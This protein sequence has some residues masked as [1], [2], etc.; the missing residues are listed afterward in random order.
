MS[1]MNIDAPEFIYGTAWKEEQTAE[2]TRRALESGFRAVDTANQ[3][4]HYHEAG[5]GEAIGEAMEEGVVERDELFVQTKFTYEAGQDHRIPYDPDAPFPEQVEQSFESS[6]DHLGLEFVDSYILHGPSMR[7]GLGEADWQVW[8]AMTEL[9]EAGRVGQI[10]VSNVSAGQLQELIEGTDHPPA[11]VQNRC[12]ARTGWGRDV[13]ELCNDTGIVY[14]GFSLLTANVQA[15]QTD[16]VARIAQR[17]DKT[18]PQVV[19]RFASQIGILPL[20]GT[21][22]EDHMRQDLD[23]FSVELDEAEIETLETIA[24]A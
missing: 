15:L 18:I 4:K 9:L 7:M 6:L 16:Q 12:F 8:G 2:L 10:G 17:H 19:F 5:V 3:R 14:Q 22:D 21:T 13:R 11:H 20:T 24:T 23:C 1:D